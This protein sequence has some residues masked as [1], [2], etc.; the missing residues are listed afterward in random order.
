MWL[1]GC[2]VIFVA[3][4][5]FEDTSYIADVSQESKQGHQSAQNI[6]VEKA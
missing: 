2:S 6:D 1:K 4:N 3:S 5:M